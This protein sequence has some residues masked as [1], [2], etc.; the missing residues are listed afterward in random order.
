MA[1]RVVGSAGRGCREWEL[2]AS[3]TSGEMKFAR[4]GANQRACK[5]ECPAAGVDLD[6][7]GL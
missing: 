1:K 3:R 4:E 5:G 7:A 2:R 6:S